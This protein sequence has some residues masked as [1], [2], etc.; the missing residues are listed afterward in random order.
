MNYPKTQ[1]KAANDIEARCGCTVKNTLQRSTQG[2][3][4][5][6]KYDHLISFLPRPDRPD[7]VVNPDILRKIAWTEDSVSGGPNV[8]Y[9]T[10]Q[11]E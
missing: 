8:S 4:N 5:M 10:S 6:G 11:V 9:S 3:L 2:E 1:E 7:E